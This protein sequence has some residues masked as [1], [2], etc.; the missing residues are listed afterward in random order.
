MINV[1]VYG[2]LKSGHGNNRLLRDSLFVGEDETV[3]DQ[4]DLRCWG[5]FPA[6]Y[7]GGTTSI[8]GELYSVTEEVFLERLDRLEGYP[9]LYDRRIISL[10]SGVEAWM[11][12]INAS[13]REGSVCPDGIWR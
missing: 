5:A 8:K 4:F 11:Y 10:K 3:N 6:V 13:D 2:T 7:L 12:Y 9:H 1:F